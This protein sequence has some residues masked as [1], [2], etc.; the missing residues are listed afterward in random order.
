M[1]NCMTNSVDVTW[2]LDDITM[3]GT[4]SIPDGEGPFPAV[5]MVAGSGP[6]DRNWCSPL[7]PG[8]NGSAR[9]FAEAFA[10]AGIASLRYDKRASGP[11]AAESARTLFGKFS[12]RSHL[13]ELVAAVTELVRHGNIDGAR[14]VGLGNSEGTLHVLHYV[15]SQHDVS[16]AGIILAAPPGR[17]VGE[18]VLSQFALQATQ[19]PGGAELMIGVKA[20]TDRY[21]IG[22]PME[23]DPRLPESVR[24]AL[25]SFESPANL[26]LARELWAES[27]SALL[28]EVEIPT[29]VLIGQKDIQVDASLDGGI[30]ERVSAG[31]DNVTFSY[32][33]HANHV[34][35]EDTRTLAEVV[36]T[37]G[38]GYNEDGTRLDP[39]ALTTI[40][41]WLHG[42]FN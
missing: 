34:F 32:P 30:L 42:L 14:I 36:A 20:A 26:P 4:L 40:L 12:M 21:E 6:T 13:D 11:H 5:I 28:S 25:A 23:L 29:L 39:E 38:Q 19:F 1:V 2:Q 7:L 33:L 8:V 27:A 16:F 31:K 37:P 24:L 3:N 17:T 15:T 35:K 41:S 9:L 18:V 10:D 22:E